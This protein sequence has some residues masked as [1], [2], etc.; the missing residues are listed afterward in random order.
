MR[1]TF[2]SVQIFDQSGTL[3]WTW[4][5]TTKEDRWRTELNHYPPGK[6]EFLIQGPD[7]CKR[8]A[9]ILGPHISDFI[10]EVLTIHSKSSL[11]KAQAILRLAER[12]GSERLDRAC[13]RALQFGA[14]DCEAV[15]TILMNGLDLAVQP[16]KE[17]EAIPDDETDY[18]F[19]RSADSFVHESTTS[20]G[21]ER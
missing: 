3:I 10:K 12:F 6:R 5:R 21:G 11:R 8:K 13:A 16:P 7:Y 9:D 4:E 20:P 18:A 17:E 14:T 2:L 1:G 15:R 19:L